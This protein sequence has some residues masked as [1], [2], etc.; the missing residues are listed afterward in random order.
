MRQIDLEKIE[1]WSTGYGLSKEKC[2]ETLVLC[3]SLVSTWFAN[4]KHNVTDKPSFELALIDAD[5][6]E[7]EVLQGIDESNAGLT[8]ADVLLTKA[9]AYS[10]VSLRSYLFDNGKKIISGVLGEMDID[11]KC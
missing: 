5:G 6:A 7:A 9:K 4:Y 2:E 8:I 11:K 1:Q 3:E 10:S